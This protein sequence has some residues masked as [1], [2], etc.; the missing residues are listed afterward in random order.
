LI[1]FILGCIKSEENVTKLLTSALRE[2]ENYQTVVSKFD[3]ESERAQNSS[4]LLLKQANDLLSDCNNGLANLTS[5]CGKLERDLI[6]RTNEL[7][8]TNR[9]LSDMTSELKRCN[10]LKANETLRATQLEIELNKCNQE[11]KNCSNVLTK[12]TGDQNRMLLDMGDDLHYAGL[13]VNCCSER[14]ALR[15]NAEMFATRYT[16]LPNYLLENVCYEGTSQGQELWDIQHCMSLSDKNLITLLDDAIRSALISTNPK[17]AAFIIGLIFFA[18]LGVIFCILL[19]IMLICWAT[20][21]G[22]NSLGQTLPVSRSPDS[23]DVQTSASPANQPSALSGSSD[24]APAAQPSVNPMNQPSASPVD[25]N[26]FRASASDDE[27]S[28]A[29]RM[30]E[31]VQAAARASDAAYSTVR[32]MQRES[33]ARASQPNQGPLRPS[34]SKP[35][36]YEFLVRQAQVR[37]LTHTYSFIF[38]HFP[39]FSQSYG[40]ITLFTFKGLF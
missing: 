28:V 13:Y 24:D 39:N 22:K 21:C 3:E 6:T 17:T 8:K 14:A 29:R 25:L 27:D 10:T 26:P 11:L 4:A 36:S 23:P 30:S 16:C 40:V 31:D 18:I 20:K 33:E 7:A 9:S 32:R 38:I 35:P 2:L 37:F 5:D 1:Y 15:C 12:V 34:R 19:L